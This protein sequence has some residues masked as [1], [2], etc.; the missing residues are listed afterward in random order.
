[1]GGYFVKTALFEGSRHLEK[2]VPNAIFTISAKMNIFAL[3]KP[4]TPVHGFG[5]HF[6]RLTPPRK[7]CAERDFHEL[8][9]MALRATQTVRLTKSNN[10]CPSTGSVHVA[11]YF[12]KIDLHGKYHGQPS[13]T[14][15]T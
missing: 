1:V 6:L 5:G 13:Q 2:V 9:F 4:C 8:H 11:Q 10:S 12:G 15:P 3:R 7:G 14:V